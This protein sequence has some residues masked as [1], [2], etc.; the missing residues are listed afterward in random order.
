M[1]EQTLQQLLSERV[2]AY[3][4]SDRP[5]ELIDAGIDKMFQDIV[6]DLFRSYGDVSKSI[7]AAIAAAMPASVGDAFEL[8]RYNA[9]LAETLRQ[10]W[11]Q[12]A[13]HSTVFEQAGKAIDE[14]LSG[15][16]LIAG[17]VSL[18]A[19]LE[20]FV[21]AHKEQAQENSWSSPEIRFEERESYGSTFLSIY[22]DPEPESAHMSSGRYGS[23]D[24]RHDFSLKHRLSIRLTGEV[25]PGADRWSGNVS[26]GEVYSAQLDDKKV[27]LQMDIRD[28]WER[29]LASL[30][31]GNAKILVDC[32]ADDFSYGVDL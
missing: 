28:K 5:R 19:L 7:K 3:A 13:L 11:E 14:I 26:V 12:A 2:T 15:D 18:R 17:E 21:S 23:R 31:F 20:E 24:R 16:G 32:E 27:C 25:R 4:Q 10:R 1:T 8:T 30:Y 6:Q 22:F 29:M 9:L